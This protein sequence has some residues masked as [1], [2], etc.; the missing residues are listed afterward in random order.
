MIPLGARGA[1]GKG[2][3]HNNDGQR[4]TEPTKWPPLAFIDRMHRIDS[5]KTQESHWMQSEST[6]FAAS[7]HFL[8]NSGR[9]AR[10]VNGKQ[11]FRSLRLLP[12]PDHPVNPVH[13]C[14][15]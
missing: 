7:L 1:L 10:I 6:N 2:G 11:R 12:Y 15:L 14:T 4:G 8:V 3:S 13:A 5:M 9:G